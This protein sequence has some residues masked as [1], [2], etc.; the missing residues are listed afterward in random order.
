[1]T[2]K[3]SL[4]CNMINSFHHTRL[5]DKSIYRIK[6]HTFNLSSSCPINPCARKISN[7]HKNINS[8]IFTIIVKSLRV[9]TNVFWK[10]SDNEGEA[11][12]LIKM[13]WCFPAKIRDPG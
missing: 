2:V 12:Y 4:N 13:M 8:E 3:L 11:S 1:M 7:S 6:K 9:V 5:F 10:T